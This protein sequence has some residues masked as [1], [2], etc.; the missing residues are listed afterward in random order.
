MSRSP[1][2]SSSLAWQQWSRIICFL[3]RQVDHRARS[4]NIDQV[5]FHLSTMVGSRRRWWTCEYLSVY[6]SRPT[7][8]CVMLD[9]TSVT[10]SKW[11]RKTSVQLCDL[12]TSISECV[13]WSLV[14]LDLFSSNIE[15]IHSCSTMHLLF[16]VVVHIDGVQHSLLWTTRESKKSI[17]INDD[18]Q[19]RLC[20]IL[21]WRSECWLIEM[22]FR[23]TVCI[24]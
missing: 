20:L 15:S 14:V 10:S 2:L 24:L 18:H 6:V 7:S 9:R 5:S 23:R 12:E 19:H 4:A 11:R 16:R 22:I 17:R 3:V 1:Q 8:S 21:S 13:G